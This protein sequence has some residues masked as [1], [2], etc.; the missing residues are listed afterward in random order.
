MSVSEADTS[1]VRVCPH[2]GKPAG[3]HPFCASC[4]LNLAG[5][6][7]LPTESEWRERRSATT[8]ED[9]E[10]TTSRR[11]QETMRLTRAARAGMAYRNHRWR[12]R[13]LGLAVIAVIAVV[14]VLVGSAGSGSSLN[15]TEVQ[16]TLTND[17]GNLGVTWTCQTDPEAT[18]EPYQCYADYSGEGSVEPAY[19]VTAKGGGCFTLSPLDSGAADAISEAQIPSTISDCYGQ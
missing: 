1:E 6:E 11:E 17:Y 16:V 9:G 19:S 15:M 2:C 7:R 5:V 3:E 18:T 12:F 4:G 13:V 8:S 10:A 14:V